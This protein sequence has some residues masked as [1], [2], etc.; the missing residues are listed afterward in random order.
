MELNPT[1]PPVAHILA[2]MLLS[3]C[4]PQ[5]DATEADE[6]GVIDEYAERLLVTGRPDQAEI[7]YTVIVG[8]L[9]K[10]GKTEEIRVICESARSKLDFDETAE[11]GTLAWICPKPS[12]D[13]PH[14][15]STFPSRP[16]R[17]LYAFGNPVFSGTGEVVVRFDIDT[18]GKVEN[19]EVIRSDDQPHD[20]AARILLR[21]ALFYP[22]LK[23]GVPTVEH[24][25]EMTI[26]YIDENDN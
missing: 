14:D 3:S 4:A 1:S 2:A 23:D 17:F 16:A 5:L 20:D 18:R 10:A 7:V 26:R 21:T 6:L 12:L 24:G 15:R 11:P 9:S 22:A 19:V 13:A 8:A 25:R